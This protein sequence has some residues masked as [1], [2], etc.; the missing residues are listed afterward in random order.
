VIRLLLAGSKPEKIL[1]L[2]YTRAAA[3]EMSTRLFGELAKWISY[4]DEKLIEEIHK[5]TGHVRLTPDELAR[6]RRLFALALET[7]GGLKIQTIHAFCEQLLHR[8]PVE[9]DFAPGFEVLD[10]RA[11][12]EMIGRV[13]NRF[14]AA[15]QPD[16]ETEDG[17]HLAQVIR[18]CGSGDGFDKLLWT[19]IGQREKLG[20]VVGDEAALNAA[21]A[22]LADF[23]G[24][25]VDDTAESMAAEFCA[26]LDEQK[27][28]QA[29]EW[30][31]ED[32]DTARAGKLEAAI[33]ASTPSEKLNCLSDLLLT[34][35]G[36]IRARPCR[37]AVV[38]KHPQAVDFFAGLADEVFAVNGRIKSVN[39]LRA[40][41]ALLQI[42]RAVITDYEAEKSRLGLYDYHDLI[43][44]TLTMLEELPGAPWVLY[45]L[46]GGIDHILVDEAQDTS[47]GQ[48]RII[49]S[50]TGEFFAGQGA[51]D[52]VL[53]TIFAVG[54]PKQSIYGFQ[55]AVPEQ[56]ELMARHFN[57]LADAAGLAFEKE[58]F[59]VSFRSAREIL[60]AV[61]MVFAQDEAARGAG[62]TVHEPRSDDLPGLV[63]VWETF[64][65][66]KKDK[67][68]KRPRWSLDDD[69][70]DGLHQR[71][72]LA[73]RVADEIDHWITSGERLAGRGRAIRPDDILILVR[74]RTGLMDALVRALKQ[75]GVPVA[76]VDRLKFT[77]HIAVEDLM[78]LGRFV[79]L[80]DDDL[81]FAGL[82]KS[83]L[84][85]RDDGTPIDDDCLLLF[86]QDRTRQSLWQAFEQHAGPG[87]AFSQAHSELRRWRAMADTMTPFRFFSE[88]LVHGGK[89]RQIFRRLGSEAGEP[90]DVFLSMALDYER[91]NTPALA[92]FL[93]WLQASETEIKRDMDQAGG[94]VRVMTVH[95]AKGLEANIV[96]LP[97][98][99]NVPDKKNLDSLLYAGKETPVWRLKDELAASEVKK[100]A[101][102]Q[103]EREFEEYN[104]LLYVAMTRARERLYVCGAQPGDKL[105]E[106]CWY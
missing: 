35:D 78:A 59:D 15:I 31:K 86:G 65:P 82:L 93:S 29:L 48:W 2:T 106:R 70:D 10:D 27:L 74:H 72:R 49:D 52:D 84:L 17:R 95:G 23:L 73:G 85:A 50:L 66:V 62:R 63:E 68:G 9:A 94:E 36:K 57:Q 44:R 105:D 103:L 20:P 46:D 19:M 37:K 6:P 14:L 38:E 39:A 79:L 75:R 13:K 90:V 45:R 60:K 51:R 4:D 40:T 34:K 81:N 76:G 69:D 42:A 87:S 3:A 54:D 33:R 99:C 58:H 16:R 56:F 96:I 61:D 32:N 24:I 98:T 26:G 53:R 92:G 80:P 77:R 1:C 64:K 101:D 5:K 8:F 11:A 83:S 88:V 7:P 89:L 71:I 22:R 12:S 91:E 67:A 55:G 104:R 21:S 43:L 97:D 28:R 41:S 25:D 30:Y 47:A 18:F 102:E 100:L